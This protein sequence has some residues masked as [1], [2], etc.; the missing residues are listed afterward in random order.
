MA[1][2]CLPRRCRSC[3]YSSQVDVG[4]DCEML[5]ACLYILHHGTRRPCPADA[6]CTVYERTDRKRSVMEL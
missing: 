3:R 6:A 2:G 4:L 1:K 5:W